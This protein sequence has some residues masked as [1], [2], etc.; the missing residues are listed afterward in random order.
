MRKIF[1][2]A[3][4]VFIFSVISPAYAQKVERL[5]FVGGPPSG[6]FGIFATGIGTYLSKNVPNLDVSVTATGGSVE[7]IRRVNGGE[8]EMGL[9][10]AS[11]VHEAYFG[12]EQFKGK[13]LTNIRAVGLVFFGVAHAITYADSGIRSVEDLAGKRVAVGTPGSGTFASAERVF[14]SLGVWDKITRIPLLGAQ[15]GEAMSD[16]KADAFFWTGPEPDRV[17]MEAA[18]KKPVRAIDIYTPATKTDF[19]KQYPY[20]ARYVFPAGSYKGITEDTSTVGIPVIWYVNKDLS[21]PLVQK[22][23]EAAY[24]K[25]GNAHMLKVHAGSKDMVPQRALQGVTFPLHKGA[26]DHWRAAGLQIPE[27][28]RTK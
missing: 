6:V 24:N 11:D 8:A 13:P 28:I 20:F 15:A 18:T 14:R 1:H 16:G 5:N 3:M 17:T 27:A 7:N 26:E 2:L 21:A 19:F 10:F 23:T 9:S 22:I 12:Q 25:D 4:A